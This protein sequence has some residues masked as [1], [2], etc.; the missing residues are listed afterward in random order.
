MNLVPLTN[1]VLVK[2]EKQVEQKTKSGIIIPE[3]KKTSQDLVIMK[4]I[5]V[6]E[7]CKTPIKPGMDIITHQY[8]GHPIEFEGEKYRVM[9]ENDI[10]MKVEGK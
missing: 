10:L 1:K 7:S 8:H 6:G 2:L 5:A 3:T 9:S 4:I